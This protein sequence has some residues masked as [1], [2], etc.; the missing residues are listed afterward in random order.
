MTYACPAWFWLSK[1]QKQKLQVVQN[2]ALRICNRIKKI[3]KVRI[4]KLHEI[5]N[6]ETLEQFTKRLSNSYFNSRNDN[7]FINNAKTLY[8]FGKLQ[9]LNLDMPW[10]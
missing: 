3:D 2:T 8:K 1:S 5:S 9:K 7:T 4:E 6:I 10:S